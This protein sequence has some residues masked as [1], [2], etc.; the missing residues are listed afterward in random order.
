MNKQKTIGLVRLFWLATGWLSLTLGAIG[1][2]LPLLPTTP[3]VLVAAF[4]FS[5]S[6]SRFHQWLL[7]HK[8]FGSL[9]RD[10]QQNGVISLKAKLLATASMV[11]LASYPLF[12]V[13]QNIYI[14]WGIISCMALVLIFIWSR[15]GHPRQN[16]QNTGKTD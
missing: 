9:I 5:R 13:L 7:T 1:V 10:W 16:G 4:A 15:P 8:L 11:L 2:V 14:R 3:F 6:S 12:F